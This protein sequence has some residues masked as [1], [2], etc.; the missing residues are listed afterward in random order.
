MLQFVCFNSA[1]LSVAPRTEAQSCSW[2]TIRRNRIWCPAAFFIKSLL[3]HTASNWSFLNYKWKIV[4]GFLR[5]FGEFHW[6]LFCL[7]PNN[8]LEYSK[9]LR[10]KTL[11][12]LVNSTNFSIISTSSQCP[13]TTATTATHFSLTT[14]RV[15]ARRTVKVENT[16]ITWNITFNDGWSRKLRRW[17]MPPQRHLRRARLH[18]IHSLSRRREL[19]FHREYQLDRMR[20]HHDRECRRTLIQWWGK[21]GILFEIS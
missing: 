12:F 14:R 15:S 9:R 18:R 10:G 3:F 19:K 8:F 11:N 2:D 1:H 6:R 13:N 7:F 20:C 4:A 21:W 5:N 16:R 17:S